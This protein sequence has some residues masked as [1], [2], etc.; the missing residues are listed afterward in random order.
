MLEGVLLGLETAFS[1]Q[2]LVL[3]VAGC[4]IGTVSKVHGLTSP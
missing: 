3:V 2:N 1:L 4:M